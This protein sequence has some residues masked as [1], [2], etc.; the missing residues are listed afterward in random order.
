MTR[1]GSTDRS[2]SG[3]PAESRL[4]EPDSAPSTGRVWA[5]MRKSRLTRLAVAWVVGLVL[6]A[7]VAP[8]ISLNQPFYW[9][10]GSGAEFPWLPALFNRLLFENTVDVFF[11]ALLILGPAYVGIWVIARRRAGPRFHQVRL[12]VLRGVCVFHAGV[13]LLL[14][15]SSVFGF[16]NPLYYT[17]KIV[18]YRVAA[19]KLDAAGK[20][21]AALFPLRRFGYRDTD[22]ER[23]MEPP[24]QRHWLG[25][26]SEGRDVFARMLYG[27]RISLSIGVVAVAIYVTIGVVL[28]ACAGYF[29]GA[30]DL[31]ISRLIEV[32]ICFPSF[33]LILTIAALIEQ[34][35]IFHVMV[36]IGMTSWTGVA[37]LVRAEFLKHKNLEYALAAV[38][39]GMGR[40]RIMFRHILPNAVAPVLVTATFGVATAILIESSLAFLGV[41]DL[42]VASWG[43]TLNTG[44]VQGKLWLVLAPGLAIFCVVSLFNLVGEGL[45]DA[46]DPRLR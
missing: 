45:R 46:L 6:L 32:M 34:R 11:N 25:T 16:D 26:D 9:N 8:V 17:E 28:G 40:F 36:V 20:S 2:T 19:E 31:W 1:R 37:R 43:E 22:P 18:D 5:R 29:G 21:Y 15:P 12:R 3:M 14:G 39:L 24:S 38:A 27:T 33:F 4:D 7:M 35:S 23:S 10:D 41:G 30:V 44:R 13:T 42:S